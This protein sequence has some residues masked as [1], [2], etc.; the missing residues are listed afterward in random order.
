MFCKKCG[1]Q[2]SDNVQF[3]KSCGAPVTN[4]A[5]GAPYLAGSAGSHPSNAAGGAFGATG[6]SVGETSTVKT[7]SL[8]L[9]LVAL[10]LCLFF[11]LPM[12]T[13]TCG[14]EI[15]FSGLD[16][17]LGKDASSLGHI[18]GNPLVILMLAI[19]IALIVLVSLKK[20]A[21]AILASIAGLLFQ[22]IFAFIVT[23]TVNNGGDSGDILGSMGG[24]GDAISSLG[25]SSGAG[26][27]LSFTPWYHL[28]WVLYIVATILAITIW[29]KSKVSTPR[30]M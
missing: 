1:Q 15:P 27:I 26:S 20:Y 23:S 9:R 3:C 24:V 29:S 25:S 11:F 8:A 4:A 7:L 17:T 5:P 18:D 16:A 14:T 2:L 30:R 12:F 21:G 28:S 22:W 10:V 13:I 19:P 6:N